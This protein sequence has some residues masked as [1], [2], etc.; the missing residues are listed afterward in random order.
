MKHIEELVGNYLKLNTDYALFITGKWGIGKTYYYNNTLVSLIK[1]TEINNYEKNNSKKFIPVYISLFGIKTIEDLQTQI[2]LSIYKINGKKAKLATS[3]ASACIRGFASYHNVEIETSDILPNTLNIR[4][5]DDLILCF[6][7]IER[8]NDELNI[9]E[10]AGYI[11]LLLENY[12]AKI[13][14]IANEKEI[15]DNKTTE[16]KNNWKE[17]K[18][19]IVGNTI[20]F[21]PDLSFSINGIIESLNTN[22]DYRSYLKE[23]LDFILE[24]FSKTS[25]NLRT[26]KYALSCFQTVFNLIEPLLDKYTEIKNNK[27]EI[28]KSLLYFTIVI[29]EEYRLGKITYSENNGIDNCWSFLWLEDFHSNNGTVELTEDNQ[30]Y[31]GQYY[32]KYYAPAMPTFYQSIYDFVTGG[33]IFHKES[34]IEQLKKD[35]HV[36]D[37]SKSKIEIL[38]DVLSR[39]NCFLLSEKEYRERTKELL[40][41]IEKGLYSDPERYVN[42]LYFV[43]RFDNILNYNPAR[44]VKR[45][46]IGLNKADINFRYYE[47]FKDR[48]HASRNEKDSL[49]EYK[50][51]IINCLDLKYQKYQKIID[52]TKIEEYEDMCKKSIYDFCLFLYDKG[53]HGILDKIDTKVFYLSFIRAN[54]EAKY[55]VT[56]CIDVVLSKYSN[57]YYLKDFLPFL[58][59]LQSLLKKGEKQ[60]A[61]KT[62]SGYCYRKFQESINGYIEKIN[63]ELKQYQNSNS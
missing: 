35:Y 45:I 24:T 56:G 5:F 31:A 7:D 34:F 48:L 2:L 9:K 18:D 15:K 39:D 13:I 27:A 47:S 30:S 57:I 44:L 40:S 53:I 25:L 61:K 37:N 28:L 41:Y 4:G 21:N 42:C 16:G 58:V 59:G 11:N 6:D 20:E 49:A 36:Y 3:I 1:N 60:Y 33:A 14:L 12:S 63:I 22:S 32:H 19:K 17:I 43:L 26:L 8:K 23:E 54:T 62:V 52:K 55:K 10:L 29:S 38:F 50:T 51:E 46:K